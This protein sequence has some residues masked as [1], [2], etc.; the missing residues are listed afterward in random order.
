MAPHRDELEAAQQRIRA[1]EDRV[2]ELEAEEPPA[3]PV[4]GPNREPPTPPQERAKERR[5]RGKNQANVGKAAV[6]ETRALV[7][8]ALATHPTLKDALVTVGGGLL[9]FVIASAAN[10]AVFSKIDAT[11]RIAR[12]PALFDHVRR[13][14][15]SGITK[16]V[17]SRDWGRRLRRL[18]DAGQVSGDAGRI[19]DHCESR[20]SVRGSRS[21]LRGGALTGS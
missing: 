10:L 15:P 2:N 8:Q 19:G 9:V 16:R 12:S 20:L 21:A 3:A 17:A 18:A 11:R 5:I 4:A 1:L 7:D 13:P 6:N 14:S